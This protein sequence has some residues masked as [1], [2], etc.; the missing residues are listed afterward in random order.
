MA[1]AAKEGEAD[2]EGEAEEGGERECKRRR[3]MSRCK[4]G[5]KVKDSSE[6][7]RERDPHSSIHRY[8]ERA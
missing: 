5:V 8:V 7:V 6:R 2:G 3:Q 1:A 4:L